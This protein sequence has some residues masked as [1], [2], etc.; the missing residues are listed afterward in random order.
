MIAWAADAGDS[1]YIVKSG[2]CVLTTAVTQSQKQQVQVGVHACRL[3][4][5]SLRPCYDW[6]ACMHCNT[7]Y[8]VLDCCSITQEQPACRNTGWS[9]S[10]CCLFMNKR[11]RGLADCR[12]TSTAH[13]S[14][15]LLPEIC[16]HCL[17]KAFVCSN[18]ECYDRPVSQHR[19]LLVANCQ[20]LDAAGCQPGGAASAKVGCAARRS[21]EAWGQAWRTG[22]AGS[23]TPGDHPGGPQG[24][25]SGVAAFD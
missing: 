10:D 6:A 12:H 18:T 9:I 13:G 8:P 24:Q 20:S 21:P 1:L 25:D 17:T 15:V 14:A 19:M 5:P 22:S 3:L 4:C 7:G 16:W 2:E 11:R 23:T